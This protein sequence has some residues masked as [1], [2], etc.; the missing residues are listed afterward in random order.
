MKWSMAS[1]IV[2]KAS[3]DLLFLALDRDLNQGTVPR[4]RM[5]ST[6]M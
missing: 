3:R 1:R 2:R 6:V 4:V 5:A